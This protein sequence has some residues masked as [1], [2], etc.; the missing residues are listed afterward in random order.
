M[1]YPAIEAKGVRF[2]YGKNEILHGMDFAAQKGQLIAVLGPNGAGKSTL[3]RCLLGLYHSYRGSITIEVKNMQPREI[4]AKVAYI[5]QTH[6]PTFHYTVLEM[7]LMGTTHRVRGLQSPGAKEVAIA[8]EALAQVGIADM[9][10]R[11]YGRLSGGEQQLVL[12]AWALA[13]QT[14]LLI[15]DEP[16]SSLDYGNQLRVMQR[17]RALAR[18][19]YTILLSS[20]NPQQAL[21]FSD[22]ILAL[23]DGVICADGTP[24]KVITPELLETL[25][26]IKTRLAEAEEG[27]LIIPLLKEDD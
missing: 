20:H 1:S 27:R 3:F 22:R 23:H 13:Q 14:E 26:S 5:P 17:V 12:I 19:G 4:A 2:S 11:S 10:S 9:E 16:T 18:Q 8:R 15:M 24:E 25:Y 21:L 7:V 6:T